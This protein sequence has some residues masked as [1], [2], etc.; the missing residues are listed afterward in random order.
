MQHGGD[1]SRAVQTYAIEK[2]KWMDLSTG[3]NP[4]GYAIERLP[5]SSFEK[6]PDA[7]DMTALAEAARRA[8]NVPDAQGLIAA[9]GSEFLIQ[10]LPQT[11]RLSKV[12]ILWPTFSS[13][14]AAWRRYGHQVRMISDLDE[15]QDETVVVIVNPNNP[16]GR[17]I[18]PGQLKKLAAQLSVNGGLLIVDEAF[19][20]VMPEMSFIPKNDLEN[21]VILRSIGK[22]FGLAGVRLGF[23][24]GANR[25]LD[26]LRESLGAWAVSGPAIAIGTKILSDTDWQEQARSVLRLQGQQ[27]EEVYKKYGVK[28][29]GGVPLFHLLE[30]DDARTIHH[31]LAKRA[32]WTRIFDYNNKWLRVG[33]CKT[34]VDLRQ[35]AD[36]LET[37]LRLSQ[38]AA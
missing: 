5:Q 17:V 13:H 23:A 4:N 12:A 19:V 37:V 38:K 15:L 36:R 8:Y 18:K 7:Q 34:Q 31:E 16:D 25:L 27:H 22:F 35:F 21:V 10:A 29:V 14:E 6:L 28:L 9:P 1:L 26:P 33:L 20:D 3:V 24:V 11:R 32:V 30:F 2:W